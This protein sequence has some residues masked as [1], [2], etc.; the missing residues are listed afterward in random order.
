MSLPLFNHKIN[1]LGY[2]KIF[3]FASDIMKIECCEVCVCRS[4]DKSMCECVCMH[5]YAGA[6]EI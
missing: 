5:M 3:N 6:Y 4:E 2:D 1:R